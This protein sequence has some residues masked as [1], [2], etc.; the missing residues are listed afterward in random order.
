MT[1]RIETEVMNTFPPETA[2][3][4]FHFQACDLRAIWNLSLMAEKLLNE[5]EKRGAA[6]LINA[7]YYLSDR[8]WYQRYVEENPQPPNSVMFTFPVEPGAGPKS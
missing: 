3:L 7:M 6:H 2:R 4:L 8:A 5:G 1:G